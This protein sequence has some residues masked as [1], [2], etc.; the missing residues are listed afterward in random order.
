MIEGQVLVT[1]AIL[2]GESIAEED[3]EP[4]E[5]R[6]ARGFDIGFQ[7][8]DARQAELEVRAANHAVIFGDN[9]HAIEE[10]GLDRIL[11]TPQRQ[12]DSSST[13]GNPR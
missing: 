9:V 4:R 6:G 11:P 2:A 12:G 13:G 5:C 10:N 1:T 8:D 7:G 3:V